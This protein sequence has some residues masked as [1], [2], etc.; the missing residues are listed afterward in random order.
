MVIIQPTKLNLGFRNLVAIVDLSKSNSFSAVGHRKILFTSHGC[1][2]IE[3]SVVCP[4]TVPV[5]HPFFPWTVC[6]CMPMASFKFY[7]LNMRK[8]QNFQ[9]PLPAFFFSSLVLTCRIQ[10]GITNG[11]YFYSQNLVYYRFQTSVLINNISSC[12]ISFV[13]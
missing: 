10:V 3:N 2:H 12:V 5:D 4:K 1:C 7:M 9:K 13:I 11:H 8:E 6:S